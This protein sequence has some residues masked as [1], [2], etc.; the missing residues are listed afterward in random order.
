MS[1]YENDD[2]DDRDHDDDRYE[3]DDD[4]YDHDDDRYEV[5]SSYDYDD[6]RY[7]VQSPVA[8]AP[9]RIHV[10][11]DA[12][13]QAF[14][15]YMAALDRTP[16]SAGLANWMSVIRSGA[17]MDDVASGFVNS[18]EFEQ[19]YG[20]LD[21]GEY[22]NQLYRNVLNRDAD[23]GGYANWTHVLE[24]GQSRESVLVGFSESEENKLNAAALVNGTDYQTWVG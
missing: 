7:I 9:V 15:L 6:S 1:R 20:D 21:N 24:S 19:K 13:G 10:D 3:R 17:S 5:H 23:Q 4:R 11:D 22:V 12:D 2:H 14:R 16:D 18:A 8:S